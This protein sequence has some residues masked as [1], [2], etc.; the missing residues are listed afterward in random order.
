MSRIQQPRFR[1]R[2]VR[3]VCHEETILWG[4]IKLVTGNSVVPLP[5]D[6]RMNY[7]TPREFLQ[8]KLRLIIFQTRT[9]TRTV[10]KIAQQSGLCC[11]SEKI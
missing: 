6:I 1:G 5:A 3:A 7:A 10:L 9:L 8:T 4:E 2:G 11:T